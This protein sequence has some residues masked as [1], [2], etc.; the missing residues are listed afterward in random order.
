MVSGFHTFWNK[1][2]QGLLDP[3]MNKNKILLTPT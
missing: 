2:F 3:D 1:V